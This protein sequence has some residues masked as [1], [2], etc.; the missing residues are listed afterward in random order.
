MPSFD[1]WL[2]RQHVNAKTATPDELETW[3]AAYEA[4]RPTQADKDEFDRLRLC[5]WATQY[6]VAGRLAARS[7]LAPIYG[8]LL[9]HPVEMYLKAELVGLVTPHDM[10]D[11]YG[12]NLEKL[13][14]RFKT[15]E[16]DSALGRFDTTIHALHEFED[17]RYPD[18]IKDGVILM[19][20]TWKPSD[21]VLLY[22]GSTSVRQYEFFISDV[23]ELVIAV[24]DR[25]SLNPIFVLGGR[26]GREALQYQNPCAAR[27]G[28]DPE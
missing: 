18:T 17:L 26:G 4:T 5:D 23:D 24:L 13:W 7:R 25:M 1:E 11:K 19:A 8:N 2:Q 22:G 28:L 9:H 27:W 12:H 16:A 20:I 15:K 21:A 14:A 6:Y 3:R 10:R